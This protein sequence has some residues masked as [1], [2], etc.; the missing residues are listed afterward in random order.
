MPERQYVHG[1][2]CGNK[3]IKRDI[4]RVTKSNHQLS[5]LGHIINGST[6][7]GIGFQAHQ[8]LLY[9]LSCPARHLRVFF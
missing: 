9:G 1:F 5:Q 3:T 2:F 8:L 6:D 7:M 4:A